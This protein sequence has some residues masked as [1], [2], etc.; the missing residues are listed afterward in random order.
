M[1]ADEISTHTFPGDR[2]AIQERLS[3]HGGYRIADATFKDGSVL[4]NLDAAPIAAQ[5]WSSAASTAYD[6]EVAAASLLENS[7]TGGSQTSSD[8]RPSSKPLSSVRDDMAQPP[9]TPLRPPPRL[10]PCEPCSHHGPGPHTIETLISST[11]LDDYVRVMVC[12][13]T[14]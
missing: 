7:P 2:G 9:I 1:D 13:L 11:S 14:R 12:Q 10:Q 4:L 5:G 3:Q 6:V 8:H